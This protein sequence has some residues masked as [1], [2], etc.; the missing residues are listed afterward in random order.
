MGKMDAMREQ[1]LDRA[2]RFI[3]RSIEVCGGKG[4]SHSYS[5]WLNPDNG[6]HRAYP[7]TT[8]YL[9]ETLIEHRHRY[10]NFGPMGRSCAQ[11]LAD[12]QNED[13]SYFSGVFRQLG[14][15]VFNTAIIAQ[16]LLKAHH[17]W[18]DF[19]DEVE[20]A[21]DWLL[22]VQ[23]S[24]GSFDRYGYKNHAFPTYYTR[25]AWALI[26]SGILMGRTDYLNAGERC[27]ER[28]LP[29]FE[30][31]E[32][33]QCGFGE[34]EAPFL[35]TVAYAVRGLIESQKH[36]QREPKRAMRWLD[37]FEDDWKNSSALPGGLWPNDYSFHCNPGE[38]QWALCY[39]SAGRKF[40]GEDKIIKRLISIQKTKGEAE[41][42]IPGS[43]PFW[44]SYSRLKYP[45]WG[46]KF[47]MDLL[48]EVASL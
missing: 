46:V 7:E 23:L 31:D 2:A 21:M 12:I 37:R 16:G 30:G 15:S 40:I 38:A 48:G 14:P 35:H 45:N 43:T 13:G 39:R 25:V 5:Y 20:R 10:D 1:A 27:L 28:L 11:W 3:G 4:S 6:W 34:N 36:L 22:S 44:G 42:G 19:G 18:G 47:F 17:I 24:D 9:I 33:R 41:G 32:I 8:G 29:R 26:E